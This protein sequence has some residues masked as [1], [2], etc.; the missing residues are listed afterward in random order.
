MEY[1]SSVYF[2][3]ELMKVDSQFG[4]LA[5][6]GELIKLDEVWRKNYDQKSGWCSRSTKE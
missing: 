3:V 5:N 1:S 4:V 6:S 2:K